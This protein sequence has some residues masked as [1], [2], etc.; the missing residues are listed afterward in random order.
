MLNGAIRWT[1]KAALMAL[2]LP[3]LGAL[4]ACES[5]YEAKAVKT[6]PAPGKLVDVGGGRRIQIDCR[7]TGGPTVVFQSGG[8]M[9]GSLAWTPVHD[10]IAAT[11]R[12]CA[13][14]RA[15]ILWSD[16]ASGKFEPEEVARDLHAALAAAGEK[17]PYVLVAHSR[18]GLY[19]MI[20]AGL[21]KD[22]VAGLVF[23][24][25]SHPDQEAK[26]EEAG[27]P[28]G[29]YVTPAQELGLAFRWTG[30]MRLETYPADP[31]IKEQVNAFYPKSAAANAREAR[32]RGETLEV[33][34]RY[35][36]LINWPVVVLARELP[37]QSQARR[38]LDRHD[39]Y[40]LSADGL[41]AGIKAPVNEVVWRKLQA[42]ISTWSSRGRL[43]IVPES[44]HAFFFF[45]PEVVVGAVNE[46]L[47]ANRVVRRPAALVE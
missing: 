16:P 45:K 37:E 27:L 40:L 31:S 44:N 32:G 28:R 21:Y 41:D 39:A 47:A 20:Y 19:N 33:A 1:L 25:S 17:P 35:R 5:M 2:A 8:D 46:V 14:S 13:Y 11:T 22:E 38:D 43:Q 24:D 36:D 23:A 3:C 18:G 6:Y 7:G 10:K 29:E 9:L 26:F 4:S 12:A 34:G 42:D 30:L 15:G